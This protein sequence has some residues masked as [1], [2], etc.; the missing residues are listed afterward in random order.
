MRYVWVKGHGWVERRLFSPRIGVG[1]S[2]ITDSIEVRS[3]ANGQVYDSK[4]QYRADLKAR[5]LVELGNE[6]L[7]RPPPEPVFTPEA[8]A[9]A[10]DKYSSMEPGEAKAYA[11]GSD[12]P[13]GWEDG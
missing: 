3:M 7:K 13:R 6:Q 12:A 10:W 9:D 8:I 2:I 11:R 1:P 5:G 4:S